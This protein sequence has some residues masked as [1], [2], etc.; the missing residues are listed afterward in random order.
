M[1]ELLGMDCNVPTDIVFSFRGFS[2]R[3]GETGPHTDG[4]GVCLYEGRSVRS[5]REPFPAAQSP[6]ARYLRENSIKTKIGV[7]HIRR[8]TK[9][10]V[11]LSNTHPFTRELWG[12]TWTFAH[13]GKVHAVTHRP[14][15]RFSPIGTTD[16][17]HAFCWMMDS[18]E[19]KF[20]RYPEEPTRLWRFVAELGADIGQYGNFN[21]LLSDSTYLFAR[22]HTN[23]HY[24]VRQHPFKHATLADDDVTINFAEHTTP[25]DRV[26][27]IATQP[28]TRDETWV[29]GDPG[30]LWVFSA[31]NLRATLPRAHD[32]YK[33]EG[34]A[35]RPSTSSGHIPSAKTK[36][37]TPRKP[38][39]IA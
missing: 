4:W 27:V 21:F 5:F 29:K 14:L 22:C 15:E 35:W 19:R 1:C 16:S 30:T 13:N 39:R 18:L 12:R 38:S 25:K 33:E 37:K 11:Q 7:G 31:G 17:E 8:K 28:L 3:G 2:K 9:G 23:L 34:K 24:L 26:A 20:R 6:L 32:R 10:K 36:P